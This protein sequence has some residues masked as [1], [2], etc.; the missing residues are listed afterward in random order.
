M[1]QVTVL[2]P[3]EELPWKLQ[4]QSTLLSGKLGTNT[5]NL[6]EQKTVGEWPGL[7]SRARLAE[8]G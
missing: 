8:S 5:K 6:R 1:E 7:E 2:G 3:S 4:Q